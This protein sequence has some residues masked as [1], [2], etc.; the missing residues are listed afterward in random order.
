MTQDFIIVIYA[1]DDEYGIDR[2][3]LLRVFYT[4]PWGNFP[5]QVR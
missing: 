2:R 3:I 4:V 1:A 5:M